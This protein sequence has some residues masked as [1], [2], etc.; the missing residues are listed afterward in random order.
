[1]STLRPFLFGCVSGVAA[2]L[3]A[4][5]LANAAKRI[6]AHQVRGNCGGWASQIR[7]NTLG[8]PWQVHRKKSDLMRIRK[9]HFCS[10]QSI[11]FE[12]TGS[13]LS[14]RNLLCAR[15]R[16][17]ANAGGLLIMRGEGQYLYD[18]LGKRYLDTRNN[19]CHVGHCH[20]RVVRAVCEQVVVDRVTRPPSP[21]LERLIV[22]VAVLNTN[23]RYLH[24]N[25]CA[26]A[27]KLLEK[28]PA[29]LDECAWKK[30]LTDHRRLAYSS[31]CGIPCSH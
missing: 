29:P 4:R 19:V 25:V 13:A 7:A 3:V 15:E 22:Q 10:A 14:A 9:E 2:L 27:T 5:L 18:E 16:A 21:C 31:W 26:L 6:R 11:S 8:A 28:C 17:V 1:M 23:L 30:P 12:D 24:P 20:P